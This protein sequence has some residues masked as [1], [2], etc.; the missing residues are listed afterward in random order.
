MASKPKIKIA[1][2]SGNVFQDLGLG[3][4]EGLALK[5]SVALRIIRALEDRDLTQ[6]EAAKLLGLK[7]PKVSAL[8]NGKISGFSLERLLT[9]LAKLGHDVTISH[10]KRRKLT[11]GEIKFTAAA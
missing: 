11:E 8:L 6:T 3:D 7:Q 9:F 5:A 1:K 2:S 4:P 10:K